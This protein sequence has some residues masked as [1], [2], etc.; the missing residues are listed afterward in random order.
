MIYYIAFI[1]LFTVHSLFIYRNKYIISEKFNLIDRPD[2]L[3]KYHS[4]DGYLVGGLILLLL[5]FEILLLNLNLIENLF[6]FLFFIFSFLIGF[7]DDRKILSISQ[8]TYLLII[9]S[10]IFSL[11]FLL[12]ESSLFPSKIQ[13]FKYIDNENLLINL[14]ICSFIFFLVYNVLNFSDGINYLVIIFATFF[15]L[16]L[17]FFI[18]LNTINI[19]IILIIGIFCLILNNK[20]I[21]LGSSGILI[22]SLLVYV[23]SIHFYNLSYLKIEYIFSI[24]TILGSDLVRLFFERIINKKKPWLGDRNH[25]HHILNNLFNNDLVVAVYL[26]FISFIPI[27]IMH[28]YEI[29]LDLTIFLGILLYTLTYFIAKT[30]LKNK[31]SKS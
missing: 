9:T 24:F 6:F 2:N 19:I 4:K 27:I 29:N 3:K 1:I 11:I 15:F 10:L 21:F 14:L 13:M 17:N 8:R 23:N 7:Y 18:M 22:I 16:Y 12:I 31:N 5:Y 25:I 28:T 26:N 20:M 30:S